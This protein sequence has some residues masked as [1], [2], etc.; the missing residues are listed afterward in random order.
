MPRLPAVC[1]AAHAS[2]MHASVQHTGPRAPWHGRRSRL[3]PTHTA[4]SLTA[5]P[6][7]PR[8]R[9]SA[10]LDASLACGVLRRSCIMHACICAAY[11]PESSVA[12]P[13]EPPTPNTHRSQ[14]DRKSPASTSTPLSCVPRFLCCLSAALS[15]VTAVRSRFAACPLLSLM[16]SLFALSSPP[17]STACCTRCEGYSRS[18]NE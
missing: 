17:R 3:R 12:W 4:R 10:C 18:I 11:G 9:L 2:C 16:S 5:S 6:L 13:S 1:C 14:F 15:A 7:P 8:V